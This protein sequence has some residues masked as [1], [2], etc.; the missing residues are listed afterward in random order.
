M[1]VLGLGEI[2][3][4]L[5]GAFLAGGHPVTVWNR[6]EEK[7]G[8]LVAAGARRAESVRDAVLAA[9]LVVVSVKGNDA[10]REILARAGDALAGR[11]VVNLTDGTSA[12]ARDVADW[13]GEQGAR[14]LHGQIMT[15]APGIGHPEAVVFYGGDETVYDTHRPALALLGGRGTFV[16]ADAG[17]PT[18]YGM[19]VHGTMWGTLNGFLHAAALLAAEGIEAGHFLERAAPSVAALTSFLPSIAE[20]IDRGRYAV[21]FGALRHHLPSVADLLRESR[22]RGV[23]DA[24]PAYTLDLVTKAVAEGHADDSY[25]RLVEHFRRKTH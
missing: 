10:A 8:P 3:A 13:A 7:A 9:P 16:A 5:A 2:G 1:T 23:D 12:E 4:A 14:Y 21:E 19:A 18:L 6:T 25:S 17:V 15:I 24:L 20:E 11:A 22:S